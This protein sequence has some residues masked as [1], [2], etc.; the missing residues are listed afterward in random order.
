VVAVRKALIRFEDVGP[1]G[2]Y[3]SEEALQNLRLMADYLH[4][5]NVPFH[6]SM[7]P[8]FVDPPRGY[9]KS[10]ADTSDPFVQSFL[11]TMRYLQDRGASLGMHG[12]RHQF[13]NSVTADGY[14]FTHSDSAFDSPP[15]D[16]EEAGLDASAFARSYTSERMRDGLQAIAQ[17]GLQ[18]DWF[19]TPH[20]TASANQR[21]ILE[22][23]IGLFFENKPDELSNN[24]II[25]DVDTP[26]HRGVIYVPTP[27]FYIDGGKANEEIR[28][29][30][31]E[32]KAYTADDL[33][34]FFFHPYLDFPFIHRTGSST[35]YEEQS[36]LKQLIRGFKQQDFRFVPLLSL[37]PFAPSYR[38]TNFFPGSEFHFFSGDFDG[39]NQDEL[40]IWHPARGD[41]YLAKGLLGNYPSRQHDKWAVQVLLQ[42]WKP[43]ANAPTL[44]LI[45]DFNGDGRDD[46]ALWNPRD[47]HLQFALSS[48]AHLHPTAHPFFEKGG[49]GA[50]WYPFVG[51]FD[52]DGTDEIAFWHP[53]TGEWRIKGQSWLSAFAVGSLW[54]PCVG[55]FNGDGRDDLIAWNRQT[56]EWQVAFGA[57]GRFLL[58]A[59]SFTNPLQNW[60]QGTDW[61]LYAADF[62]ADGR[63]DLLLVNPA[64]GNWRVALSTESGLIP[65]EQALHPWA[66][67]A[68]TEP[69]V[70]RFSHDGRAALCARHPFLRGGVIDFAVSLLGKAQTT[71]QGPTSNR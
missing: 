50:P 22:S 56:G 6:V 69:L 10:I 41:G 32:I 9:D 46:L 23:W 40:L 38:Q 26:L 68:Y 8:R 14:E 3:G 67:G 27:L 51:D 48:G 53:Y 55:D 42:Q 44:P 12:Y 2:Y 20:Y 71:Q 54:L 21:N 60:V 34:A 59:D 13:G 25:S 52:G 16:P 29:M 35:I 64:Q 18:V 47:G 57:D 11:A 24:L 49:L 4:S 31:D 17:S 66:V 33:A 15:D 1:G 39:D 36:Y 19:S 5:E 45:G 61:R 37:V 58:G 70:G 30:L 63:D 43:F 62:N 28:R 7:I 65:F